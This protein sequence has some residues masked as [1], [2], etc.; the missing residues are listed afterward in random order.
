MQG[1]AIMDKTPIVTDLDIQA[2]IDGALDRLS[3]V[4]VLQAIE[5]DP[6]LYNRYLLYKRQKDLLKLW[7]KDN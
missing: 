1:L 3:S 6:L 7:W 2:L 5:K 4:G